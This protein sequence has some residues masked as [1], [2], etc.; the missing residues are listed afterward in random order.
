MKNLILTLPFIFVLT[1]QVYSQIQLNSNDNPKPGE[2]WGATGSTQQTFTSPTFGANQIWNYGNIPTFPFVSNLL[3]KNISGTPQAGIF[4]PANL[5]GLS[6]FQEDSN[7]VGF[8][9]RTNGLFS[10]GEINDQVESGFSLKTKV[11][12]PAR[13]WVPFTLS[14]GQQIVTTGKSL[15]KRDNTDNGGELTEIR[16]EYVQTIRLVGYGTLTTPVMASRPAL[17]FF[18]KYVSRDSTFMTINGGFNPLEF[19]N[20]SIDSTYRLSFI[21]KGPGLFAAT[22]QYDSA[23]GVTTNPNFFVDSGPSAIENQFSDIHSVI[24]PNP[25]VSSEPMWVKWPNTATAVVYTIAGKKLIEINLNPHQSVV[26]P[27]EPFNKGIFI[28]E[29]RDQERNIVSRHKWIRN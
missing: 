23:S 7:Y 28:L 15:F 25:S 1:G 4:A 19:E 11:Y 16:S 27:L 3:F 26:I 22:F 29:I 18:E 5:M 2:I 20:F 8:E 24:Y 12:T 13:M 9:T 21:K 14:L 10:N 6:G 17:L